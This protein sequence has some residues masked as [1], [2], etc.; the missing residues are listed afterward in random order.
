MLKDVQHFGKCR[1]YALSLGV[2]NPL[3]VAVHDELDVGAKTARNENLGA[4][5]AHP[6][7]PHLL[8][9]IYEGFQTPSPPPTLPINKESG[10]FARTLEHIQHSTW[11]M[12]FWKQK[13]NIKPKL[14][15]KLRAGIIKS[16]LFYVPCWCF[17]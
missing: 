14:R 7:I 6:L 15:K 1:N 12:S 3:H 2:W 4:T 17:N 10:M 13:L 8:P 9:D 16:T 5:A 11:H